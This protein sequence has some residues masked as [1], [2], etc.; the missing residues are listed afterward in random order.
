MRASF[1]ENQIATERYKSS[2]KSEV[3]NE[4]DTIFTFKFVPYLNHVVNICCLMINWPEG[5][6][7][8]QCSMLESNKIPCRYII[9]ALKNLQQTKLPNLIIKYRW[10]VDIG[11]KLRKEFHSPF[12]FEDP[13]HRRYAQ[14]HKEC[15]ELC[16]LLSRTK[17]VTINTINMLKLVESVQPQKKERLLN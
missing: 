7:E 15:V 16:L 14:L 8:C 13:Q 17:K 3:I 4:D 12:P 1:L 2:L 10:M 11:V 9:S 6:F 5:T